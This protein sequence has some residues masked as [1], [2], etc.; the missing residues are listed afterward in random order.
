M[1]LEIIVND[2]KELVNSPKGHLLATAILVGAT[3]TDI[4]TTQTLFN[5]TTRIASAAGVDI[6]Q[7]LLASEGG[8]FGRYIISAYGFETMLS[9][10]LLI[11]AGVAYL[12]MRLPAARYASIISGTFLT[13]VS[14]QN[15]IVYY[16]LLPLIHHLSP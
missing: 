4:L 14:A 1:S 11:A 15:L 10:K 7:E 2:A 12:G 6:W 5:E 3:I 9:L 8:T 13:Y 16:N